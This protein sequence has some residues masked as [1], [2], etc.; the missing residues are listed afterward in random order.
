MIPLIILLWIVL[1]FSGCAERPTPK[2][3]GLGSPATET[4]MWITVRG[5]QVEVPA[6]ML[7]GQRERALREID[8]GIDG[9]EQAWGEPT[10]PPPVYIWPYGSG[11]PATI[12]GQNVL[13][14]GL[15]DFH[16]GRIVLSWSALENPHFFAFTHELAHWVLQDPS[17]I[18]FLELR[19]SRAIASGFRSQTFP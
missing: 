5:I 16:S 9:F 18:Q 11:V 15:T 14:G 8:A 13:V 7:P 10:D 3:W 6:W 17:H 12:G 19:V 2:L 1:A 4:E